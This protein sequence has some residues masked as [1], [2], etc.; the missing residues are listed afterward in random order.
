M[1]D[2]TLNQI[3]T[4]DSGVDLVVYLNSAFSDLAQRVLLKGCRSH[5]SLT[6]SFRELRSESSMECI[7]AA[8]EFRIGPF[9]VLVILLQVLWRS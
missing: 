1:V 2:Q 4:A 8:R 7:L 6:M 3:Y 9:E 5:R